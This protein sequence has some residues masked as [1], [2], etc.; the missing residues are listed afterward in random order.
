MGVWQSI[1]V[2]LIIS[3]K[4]G[5]GKLCQQCRL[6]DLIRVSWSAL[7]QSGGRAGPPDQLSANEERVSALGTELATFLW[8]NDTKLPLSCLLLTMDSRA[9]ELSLTTLTKYFLVNIIFL[10]MLSI[11]RGDMPWPHLLFLKCWCEDKV[12]DESQIS[13]VAISEYR[14][15]SVS[16]YW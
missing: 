12:S 9:F 10:V 4:T 7:S 1:L 11:P 6:S 13:G 2:G 5:G 14:C 16:G 15:V 3:I 8:W